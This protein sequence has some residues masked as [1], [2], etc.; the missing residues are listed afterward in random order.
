M[1]AEAASTL[2]AKVGAALRAK[3][4]GAVPA[5]AALLGQG[6]NASAWRVP[7]E[8]G[9]LVVRVPR[10]AWAAGEIERQSCLMPRLY[11]RGFPVV[12]GACV[13]RDADGAVL[14][15]VHEYAEGEPA[16]PRGATAR[17][18][19][20]RQVAALLSRL[21]ALP[22]EHYHAC[23]AV[24]RPPWPGR[25][26]DL[27]ARLRGQL[28]ARS[29]A[30]VDGVARRLRDAAATAPPPVPLHDDLQPAH[31][32]LDERGTLVAVLDWSGPQIGDP[33]LDFRR[34]V[35]FFGAPFAELT[36]GYYD[37]RVDAHFA[38]R[39]H[40]YAALGPLM[41]IEAGT[42]RGL[43]YWERYGRR[44][45]AARAAASTRAGA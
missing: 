21:H 2:P 41:T 16:H 18:T 39:M 40:R 24:E 35:Q 31:L 45:I 37:G 8:G 17:D 11:A 22:P 32:L 42:D 23:D 13:L 43:P 14:A 27:V 4:D 25:F 38:E 19:L 33:A 36:L 29:R 30:W 34:L 20:A 1:T 5:R 26:G 9:D 6:W 28:P 44:Q 3:H 10:L 12:A 15:G 7:A